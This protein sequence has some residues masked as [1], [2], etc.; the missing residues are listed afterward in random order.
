MNFLLNSILFCLSL[1]SW[2]ILKAINL[3]SVLLHTFLIFI[4]INYKIINQIYNRKIYLP[5]LVNTHKCLHI[6][7][8]A[9]EGRNMKGTLL[10][11]FVC[12]VLVFGISGCGEKE[13]EKDGKKIEE[14]LES[15]GYEFV[16]LYD[17]SE[18]D[19]ENQG[20]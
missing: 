11:L 12:G 2:I 9:V 19:N 13:L 16:C 5:F 6:S 17:E 7:A 3:H 1:L 18:D 8:K 20:L 14:I 4:V 10:K 15:E